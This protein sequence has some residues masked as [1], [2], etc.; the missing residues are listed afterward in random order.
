M[1]T[2]YSPPEIFQ[3]HKMGL[4]TEKQIIDPNSLQSC[5]SMRGHDASPT[6]QTSFVTSQSNPSSEIPD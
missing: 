3:A 4:P 5:K 2:A 1:R 6:T